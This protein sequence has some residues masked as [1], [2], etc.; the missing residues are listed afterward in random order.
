VELRSDHIFLNT[1]AEIEQIFSPMKCFFGANHLFYIKNFHDGSEIVLSNHPHWTE[2]F[3]KNSLHTIHGAHQNPQLFKK[4]FILN[5]SQYCHADFIKLA[6]NF[7]MGHEI[8]LIRPCPDGCEFLGLTAPIEDDQALMRFMSN[9]DLLERFFDYFRQK[10]A[11]L[12]QQAE[13]ARVIVPNKFQEA[14]AHVIFPE[15]INR[16]AFLSALQ[17]NTL[18]TNRETECAKLMIKGYTHKMI[19]ASLNISHRTV[20]TH[21]EHIKQKTNSSSKASLLEYLELNLY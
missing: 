21:I 13:R 12:I 20:S 17:M 3:F 18:L 5:H 11:P 9:M 16:H 7:Q 8:L 4:N 14:H 15:E 19:A 1:K 2:F 6:R 10:A